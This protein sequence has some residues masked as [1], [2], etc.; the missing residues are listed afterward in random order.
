M[1]GILGQRGILKLRGVWAQALGKPVLPMAH[2]AYLLR[3]QNFIEPFM[4]RLYDR[5]LKL[6]NQ[7]KG[8]A[9]YDE[10]IAYLIAYMKKYGKDSI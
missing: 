1:L 4:T 6:N 10:V 3:N 2:P 8:K 7:P 9:T 5:Y